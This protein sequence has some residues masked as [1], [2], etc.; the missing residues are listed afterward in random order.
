M[1]KKEFKNLLTDVFNIIG[2]LT[3][4]KGEE[5]AGSSDQLAN[6]RRSAQDA[7]ISAEQAWLVFFNKH[8][9]AIKYHIRRP[10]NA[11]YYPSEPIEGRA[12]DAILYLILF[13]AIQR[14][15]AEYDS[16]KEIITGTRIDP[17]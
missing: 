16:P 4:T 11:A 7:G 13:I 12:V 3:E 9:D 8:A 14:D 2:K 1:D 6:F 5:Y 17:T 10:R 15:R